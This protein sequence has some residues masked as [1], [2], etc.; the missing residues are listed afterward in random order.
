MSEQLTNFDFKASEGFEDLNRS[1]RSAK[2]PRN[3]PPIWMPSLR[4]LHLLL[5]KIPPFKSRKAEL[6]SR[7][8]PLPA[9][10]RGGAG[11]PSSLP[12]SSP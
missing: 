8:Q 5:F 1:K 11:Q 4:F 3:V 10:I 12:Q 7:Q 6:R 2:A 9:G